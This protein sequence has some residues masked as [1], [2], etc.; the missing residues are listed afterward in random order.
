MRQ[1]ARLGA[2]LAGDELF[3]AR[4]AGAVDVPLPEE[5][6][7]DP[8]PETGGSD[9]AADVSAVASRLRAAEMFRR[10]IAAATKETTRDAAARIPSRSPVEPS[11]SVPVTRFGLRESQVSHRPEFFTGLDLAAPEGT[12]VIAPADGTVQFAGPVPSKLGAEW[13][14]LGTVVVLAH[15][16][17]T[18]TPFGHLGKTL[19]R[20]RRTCCRGD[21]IGRVGHSGF[22]PAPRL[23]YQVRRLDG[24]RFVPRDPR[25]FV[26]DAEWISAA[27][28]RAAP[29]PP[30]DSDL[31][32][33]LR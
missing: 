3:L 17:R 18:V 24:S 23:H 2:R 13:R 10:Q 27:E 29:V 5:F 19:V 11:V 1:T 14:L 6:P 8:P 12:T 31:P 26:L 32:P 21:A 25:L 7:V 33:L 9:L 4:L 20:P 30:A 22:T 28:V 15:D 16:S